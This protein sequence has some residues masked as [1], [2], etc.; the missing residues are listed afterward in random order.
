MVRPEIRSNLF[1]IIKSTQWKWISKNRWQE[2]ERV[3]KSEIVP[4]RRVF[5]SIIGQEIEEKVDKYIIVIPLL[6]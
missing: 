4:N 6:L 3:A 5:V 2:V 1:K